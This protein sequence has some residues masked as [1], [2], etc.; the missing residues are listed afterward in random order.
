MPLRAVV[1]DGNLVI[2]IG[3]RTIAFAFENGEG[4]NPYDEASGE[5]KR[6]F[7]IADPL[8]FAEDICHEINDEGE[9]GSTPLT[10]F[11]DSMMDKAVENGGLGILDPEDDEPHTMNPDG[12][13][14]DRAK[15]TP[16]SE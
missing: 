12:V 4:N 8:Q 5:F 15:T 7:Q 9:D 6:E 3:I 2:S 11:L 14:G 10:R 13:D 1:Q 16:E